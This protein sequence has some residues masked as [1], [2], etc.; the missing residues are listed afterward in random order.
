M[1][2]NWMKDHATGKEAY[3][4]LDVPVADNKAA[5]AQLLLR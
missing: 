5:L 3:H 2:N 1:S 4:K